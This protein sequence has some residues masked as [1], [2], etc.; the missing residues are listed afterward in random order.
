MSVPFCPYH[1][2]QYHFV[3]ISFCDFL[4]IPFC[5]LP[6]CLV[7]SYIMQQYVNSISSLCARYQSNFINCLQ[8]DSIPELTSTKQEQRSQIKTPPGVISSGLSLKAPGRE[9]YKITALEAHNTNIDCD[10]AMQS[11]D[12]YTVRRTPRCAALSVINR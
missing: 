9:L 10:S 5:P 12:L 4:S 11:V 8:F 1:F 7:T 2:V 6:F 3:R